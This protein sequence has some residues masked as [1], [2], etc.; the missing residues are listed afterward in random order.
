MEI[1]KTRDCNTERKRYCCSR[2]GE[3][4][5]N[6]IPRIVTWWRF[7]TKVWKSSPQLRLTSGLILIDPLQNKVISK[8]RLDTTPLGDTLLVNN[9]LMNEFPAVIQEPII[10]RT[11]YFSGDFATYDYHSVQAGSKV[12]KTQGE[13]SSLITRWYKK[14]FWLYYRPLITSIFNDYYTSLKKK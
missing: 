1:H 5:R 6:P 8:F 14:I 11:Y 13:S 7:C 12:W 10:Q 2:R 3:T 4:M 9:S